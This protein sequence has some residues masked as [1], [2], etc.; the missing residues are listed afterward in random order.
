MPNNA[1]DDPSRG[2][3]IKVSPTLCSPG[4]DPSRGRLSHKEETAATIPGDPH[5]GDVAGRSSLRQSEKSAAGIFPGCLRLDRERVH[6]SPEFRV[7][8]RIDHAMA[9]DPALPFEGRR[10][11][12]DPEMRLAARPVAGM[13][14]VQ[15]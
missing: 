12:I 8:G 9:F 10:H 4:S 14:L 3:G 11:D 1:S 2:D 6:G 5:H 15:M 13:A 7:Q